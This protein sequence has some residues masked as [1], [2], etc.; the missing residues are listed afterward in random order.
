MLLL[1]LLLLLLL[2]R[3]ALSKL[4]YRVYRADTGCS[5]SHRQNPGGAK[6]PNLLCALTTSKL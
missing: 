4:K 5:T 3:K 2:L 6:H 1:P